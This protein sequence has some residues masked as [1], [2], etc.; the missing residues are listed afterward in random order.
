L[1]AQEN[2]KYVTI[3]S[4]KSLSGKTRQELA[5]MFPEKLML[6]Q[7]DPSLL[8]GIKIRTSDTEFEVSVK[9]NLDSLVSYLMQQYD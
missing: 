1:K 6:Y 5:S 7:T 2:K 3:T 8:A 4:A 9:N